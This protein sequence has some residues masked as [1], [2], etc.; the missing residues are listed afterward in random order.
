ML[1]WLR[2][3]ALSEL[4]AGAGQLHDLLMC[5]AQSPEGLLSLLSLESLHALAPEIPLEAVEP[6]R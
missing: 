6:D 4:Q 5:R 1:I 3:L 2:G